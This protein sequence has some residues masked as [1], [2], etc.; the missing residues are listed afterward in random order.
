MCVWIRI[1]IHTIY[2][3]QR[4]LIAVPV[5]I[6]YQMQVMLTRAQI[7][8]KSKHRPILKFV[9][10]VFHFSMIFPIMLLKCQEVKKA[11]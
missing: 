4:L 3:P 11:L 7:F 9:T 1:E 2:N 5:D 10:Y 8:D 6:V